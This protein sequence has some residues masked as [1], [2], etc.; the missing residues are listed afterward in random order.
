M[1]SLLSYIWGS[2]KAEKPENE[3]PELAMRE[4]LD[5]HADFT[6]EDDGTMALDSYI[7]LRSVIQRQALR[8][9][10]PEKDKLR[11]E[12]LEL[13]K[14]NPTAQEYANNFG[15]QQRIFMEAMKMMT[16]KACE[17]IDFE[18][19]YFQKTNKKFAESKDD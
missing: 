11:A 13:Y 19:Q 5:E 17:W 14:K 18:M 6:I 12:S 16:E 10:A 15:Q 4:A 3:N 2:G 7:V 9:C 1:S 8:H